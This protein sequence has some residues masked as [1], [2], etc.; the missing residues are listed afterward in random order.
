VP[1]R[2]TDIADYY[3]WPISHAQ[4][5]PSDSDRA[6]I[7]PAVSLGPSLPD[8]RDEPTHNCSIAADYIMDS[9]RKYSVRGL[10]WADPL[11][12]AC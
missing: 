3:S 9:S 8:V 12:V 5:G 10:T 2:Y 1:Y 11:L 6:E 4:A 7:I